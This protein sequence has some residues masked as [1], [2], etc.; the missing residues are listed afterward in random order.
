[1]NPALVV[2]SLELLAERQT[3]QRRRGVIDELDRVV[4]EPNPRIPL[5]VRP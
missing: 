5:I 4:A 2:Q 3:A 1:M